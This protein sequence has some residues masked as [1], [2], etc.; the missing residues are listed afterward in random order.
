[1][2]SVARAGDGAA[3]Y[4][5]TTNGFLTDQNKAHGEQI[6]RRDMLRRSALVARRSSFCHESLRKMRR[7]LLGRAPATSID[8]LSFMSDREIAMGMPADLKRGFCQ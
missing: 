1:V 3:D 5:P 8:H 7:Q 4:Y 2:A 6:N